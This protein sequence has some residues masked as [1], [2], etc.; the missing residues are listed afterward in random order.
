MPRNTQNS[1][2]GVCR[3]CNTDERNDVEFGELMQSK[4]M[5][6]H[7]FCLVGLLRF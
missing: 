5:V 3:V 1:R 2:R 6:A 4:S 7:Y